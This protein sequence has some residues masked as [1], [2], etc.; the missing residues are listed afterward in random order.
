[1]LPCACDS[2]NRTESWKDAS[3][4]AMPVR[5]VLLCTSM[6]RGKDIL[7]NSAHNPTPLSD[8]VRGE[9]V[10]DIQPFMNSAPVVK[11]LC[12]YC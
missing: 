4:R 3:L 7:A 10:A 6:I 1:M 8:C 12:A 9:R 5:Q 11:V 2:V